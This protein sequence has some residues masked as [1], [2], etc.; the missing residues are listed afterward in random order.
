MME[1]FLKTSFYSKVGKSRPS[2]QETAQKE[3]LRIITL[4]KKVSIQKNKNMIE[5]KILVFCQIQISLMMISNKLSQ[6][7][8]LI[9]IVLKNRQILQKYRLKVLF[10][11]FHYGQI[12]LAYYKNFKMSINL[13]MLERYY[14]YQY[15]NL[16]QMQAQRGKEKYY[17][18]SFIDYQMI[19]NIKKQYSFDIQ[20]LNPVCQ[21]LLQVEMTEF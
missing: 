7:G 5:A 1:S 20:S 3:T 18:I 19:M 14:K 9:Q 6:F 12:I 13:N 11:K 17:K 4:L 15:R 8:L 2:T 10:R 21:G 16:F